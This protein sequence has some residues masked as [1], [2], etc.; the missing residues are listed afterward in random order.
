MLP[1]VIVTSVSPRLAATA[2]ERLLSR[3]GTV[4]ISYAG[5]PLQRVTRTSSEV[6]EL[7]DVEPEGDCAACAVASDAAVA[8]TLLADLGRWTG[9]VICLPTAMAAGGL[10][11]QLDPPDTGRLGLP[12]DST[13]GQVPTDP[14]AA[15]VR[16]VLVV[17]DAATVQY[18]LSG[19]ELLH[20]RGMA[21]SD[22][23]RRS[24]AEAIVAQVEYADTLLLSGIE[25][26]RVPEPE[27]QLVQELLARLNP[28]AHS[29][30]WSEL[31]EFAAPS[32]SPCSSSVFDGAAAR[33][34]VE[35][36]ARRHRAA[37]LGTA[38]DSATRLGRAGL[39]RL[40]RGP[41]LR[42]ALTGTL[43]DSGRVRALLDRCL[44]DDSEYAAGPVSWTAVE[45]PFVDALGAA[46]TEPYGVAAQEWR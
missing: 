45:D 33:A 35:L 46:E 4:G 28:G 42:L 25:D 27:T 44:L 31:P 38:A 26:A 23:D 12:A 1:V 21:S 20:E 19:D 11:A 30:T 43:S 29:T 6:V 32:G 14:S 22:R 34:R 13:I 24:V 36:L 18:D 17:V 15:S 9:V 3:T 5:H 7:R 37:R 10:V 39:G 40:G 41:L 2:I 8:A 16:S